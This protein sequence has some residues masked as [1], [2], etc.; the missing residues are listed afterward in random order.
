MLSSTSRAICACDNPSQVVTHDGWTPPGL[1]VLDHQLSAARMADERPRARIVHG[2]GQI[3]HHDHLETE[4]CHL[5]DSEGA[6]EDTDVCVDAHQ[7]DVGDAFLLAEVVDFLTVVADTVK[8]DNIQ[9][10]V[11]ARPRIR[12]CPILENRI[13]A[14]ARSIVN[15]EVALLRGVARA[16]G[17]N[18]Y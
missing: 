1:D 5:P 11:F 2:I 16:T 3:P 17:Q 6:V 9:G 13:I 8:T 4:L 7:S 18:R 14:A 10:W 15:R 12:S